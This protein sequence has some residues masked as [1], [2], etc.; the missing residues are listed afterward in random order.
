VG[1]DARTGT[2]TGA[3]VDTVGAVIV[4]GWVEGG[5]AVTGNEVGGV[6]EV[7]DWVNGR[8]GRM[9]GGRVLDTTYV[10]VIHAENRNVG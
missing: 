5:V 10:W 4:G 6:V 2:E 8:L 1:M 3:G 7:D 9:S